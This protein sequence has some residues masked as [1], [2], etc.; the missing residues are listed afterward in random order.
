MVP[1]WIAGQ[2]SQDEGTVDLAGLAK[3][4][5]VDL[6]LDRCM[7]IDPVANSVLTQST[8]LIPFDIASIDTGGVGQAARL[9]GNDPRLVDVRPIQGFVERIESLDDKRIAVIGGGAGGVEMAFALNNRVHDAKVSLVAGADGLL[10]AFSATVVRKVRSELGR[11]GIELIEADARFEAGELVADG[12]SLEPLDVI[13]AATG[14]GAPDWPLSGGLACDKAGFIAV[15][16]HQRSTSHR[17]IFA[18]GDIAA[19]S[20]TIVPHSGV[21]AVHTGPVLAAN[22][23]AVMEGREAR[24]SYH[25]RRHSLYLLSCGNGTAIASYGLLSAQG[26]WVA[27]LKHTIDNRW[28]SKYAKLGGKV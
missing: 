22:L 20:D 8:G 16:R 28:I 18:A 11:Q 10:P 14:S 7:A 26:R 6:V 15:D 4:A 13:I 1:G 5:G 3:R 19:R 23:R 24:R 25:P 12:R 2:Y 17:H 27:R 9:L 21:H